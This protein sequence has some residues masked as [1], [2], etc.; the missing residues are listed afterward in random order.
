MSKAEKKN[1]LGRIIKSFVK[2]CEENVTKL[3][4]IMDA[5]TLVCE[6]FL[7]YIRKILCEKLNRLNGDICA[8]FQMET[9][10]SVIL[11]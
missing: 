1:T 5:L 7:F 4:V 11:K 8:F 6:K 9:N 2:K 10:Q 3:D